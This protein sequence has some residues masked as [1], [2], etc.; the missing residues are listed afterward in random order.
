MKPLWRESGLRPSV[1]E[2][3]FKRFLRY[4]ASRPFEPALAAT[5]RWARG[6]FE[7]H[8][9]PWSCA[10]LGDAEI[11]AWFGARCGGTA[12]LAVAAVSAGPLAEEE[13]ARRWEA[14]EPERYY[15]LEC[16]AAAVVDHLLAEARRR[17]GVARHQCPGYPGWPIEDN[18]RLCAKL[19]PLAL[20]GPLAAL[21]SGMLVPKKS[22]LAVLTLPEGAA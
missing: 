10:F 1:D 12:A 15:F 20:P 2:R 22:Q 6:W 11:G 8:A 14:D 5:A 18:V 13:A 19:T 7:S 16:Y 9:A 4:P 17:L 3:V 21:P